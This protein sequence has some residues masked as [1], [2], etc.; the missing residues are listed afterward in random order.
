MPERVSASSL[1]AA[2]TR[3]VGRARRVSET[4]TC[5][6]H[7][8]AAATPALEPSSARRTAVAACVRRRTTRGSPGAMQVPSTLACA[9][10]SS[11]RA[12]TTSPAIAVASA[13]SRSTP[14]CH[15]RARVIPRAAASSA[16]PTATG[17]SACEPGAVQVGGEQQVQRLL[18]ALQ[19]V[20]HLVARHPRHLPCDGDAPRV[21]RE[22]VAVDGLRELRGSRFIEP[23]STFLRSTTMD[24]A[25][26]PA[27]SPGV[28][29]STRTFAAPPEP[30]TLEG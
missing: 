29:V 1:R 15:R 16:L 12:R 8:P 4:R 25:C 11:R 28:P 9:Q 17:V 26:S 20:A 3:S 21:R 6:R 2:R 18:E 13:D 30:C 23:M 7:R 10:A 14:V 24:L 19:V 5:A 27:A 22:H